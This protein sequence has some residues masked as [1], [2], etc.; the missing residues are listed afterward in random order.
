MIA[1][2]IVQVFVRFLVN[3]V[4]IFISVLTSFLLSLYLVLSMSVCPF[5]AAKL[6]QS[7]N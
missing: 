1:F 5:C 3:L 7:S 6:P 4:S 2:E